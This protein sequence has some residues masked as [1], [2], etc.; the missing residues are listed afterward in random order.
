MNKDH[1]PHLAAWLLLLLLAVASGHLRA[2]TGP[3]SLEQAIQRSKQ[4]NRLL[5]ADS[6]NIAAAQQQVRVS[7]S[8]LLPQVGLGAQL[9]HYFQRPVAFGFG[10]ASSPGKIPSMRLGGDQQL[11]ASLGL[12]QPI[13][14]PGASAQLAGSR[15]EEEKSRLGY[16]FTEADVV[17]EVKRTYLRILVLQ[18]RLHLQEESIVRNRKAL[19]DARSLLAQ[20]RALRIDTLRSY[21]TLRNLEPEVLRIGYA[22]ALS[23][24]QLNLLMG[25]PVTEAVVLNDSLSFNAAEQ[26][27]ADS[28]LYSNSLAR[29]ADVRMLDLDRSIR[30]REISVARSAFL[31]SVNLVSQYQ[32]ATQT[33]RFRLADA[34]YPPVF[35]VGA[36]VSVPLFAGFGRSSRVKKAEI[37]RKQA[38]ITYLNATEQLKNDVKQVLSALDEARK[39]IT[40][41]LNVNEVA[42]TSY[43]ITQFRYSRG[44]ASRLELIDAEL[45]LTTAKSNY[46]EAVYD[47]QSAKI[48]LERVR[49][50]VD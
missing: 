25:K 49:G 15:L 23:E 40:T 31:P 22:I 37:A 11:S 14:A 10:T 50:D 32:L 21:T 39:R 36:Q 33:N 48:E 2:Q 16:A 17:A 9:D 12:V 46:L 26:I 7:K 6:L 28:S 41:Q 30:E 3:L 13:F 24:Q 38:G 42:E 4:Q 47:Y 43:S 5:K 35:F 19:D 44:I 1:T 34:S 20:G 27:P 18:K 45:A 8:Q 29:R